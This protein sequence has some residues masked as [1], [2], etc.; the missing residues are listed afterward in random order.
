MRTESGAP[1]ARVSVVTGYWD[2]PGEHGRA[3]RAGW[4][5][6]ALRIHAH[7]VFFCDPVARPT[8]YGFRAGLPTT[9]ADHT[10]DR[11]VLRRAYD[12]AWTHPVHVPSL[13]VAL[14]RLDKMDMVAR[15]AEMDGETEWFAW[16][17]AGVLPYRATRPPVSPW[18]RPGCLAALPE[19]RMI[20]G[21]ESFDG[22]AWLM[23]RSMVHTMY[24]LFYDEWFRA[25]AELRD[26]RA[27]SDLAVWE[28][29]LAK[30]PELFFRLGE[31][32]PGAAVTLLA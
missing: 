3:Y 18:P 17:D 26:W 32:A 13:E 4:L 22:T 16:I 12:P 19:D 30:H 10:V 6:S 24:W 8:L 7:Y 1:E 27:G 2:I 21:G 25:A 31:G 15:A 28:R 11:M 5:A 23:H 9:W 14:V 29:L 20:H